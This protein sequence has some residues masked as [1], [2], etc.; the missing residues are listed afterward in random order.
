MRLLLVSVLALLFFS[1]CKDKDLLN[2]PGFNSIQASQD[3]L[4]AE[5]IFNDIGN[6]VKDA[7][8]DN[9]IARLAYPEYTRINADT[10][11]E[12]TLIIN[13]GPDNILFKNKL[14]RGKIVSIYSGKYRDSLTVI[15]TYFDQ[16]YI[17]NNLIE[18]TR[19][20]ENQGSNTQGN[21]WF[22]VTVNNSSITTANGVINWESNRIREWISG[23]STILNPFDDQYLIS[24]SSSGNGVNGNEF[25]TS[26]TDPLLLDLNCYAASS[27][28]I[29]SGEATISPVGYSDRLINYGDSICDCIFEVTINENNYFITL[30]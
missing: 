12:D 18:G 14:R 29:T 8:F 21:I 9:G 23:S 26:I 7:F 17:N 13:F 30:P 20:I 3:Y 19:V 1:S 5:N 24:G 27:C 2:P 16:Y 10:A 4:T 6:T 15:T 11:N 22:L 28:L 25:M